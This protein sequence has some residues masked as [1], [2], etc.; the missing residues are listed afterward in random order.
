MENQQQKKYKKRLQSA[1]VL[2]ARQTLSLLQLCRQRS[3]S[4]LST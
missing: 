2:N 4:I 1:N 3:A